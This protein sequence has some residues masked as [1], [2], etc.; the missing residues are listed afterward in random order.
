MFKN[1]KNKTLQTKAT[2]VIKNGENL[3]LDFLLKE[4]LESIFRQ[5]RK[6]T[7]YH[8]QCEWS[9]EKGQHW[10]YP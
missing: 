5:K 2:A 1:S 7:R 4:I 9:C 8:L 10:F 3:L 6:N